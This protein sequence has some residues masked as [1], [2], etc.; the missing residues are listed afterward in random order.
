MTVILSQTDALAI[1]NYLADLLDG[2]KFEIY[3]GARPAN[4]Q[5]AVTTQTKLAEGTFPTPAFG[6]AAMSGVV[7]VATANAIAD[8][9]PIA[10][11]NA[12][13]VRVKDS[14]GTV[15]FDGSVS[16]PGGGGDMTITSTTIALGVTL[17][18][19]GFNIR[20]PTGQ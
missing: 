18:V 8:I 7:A 19:I 13:W 4:P 9:T 3:N 14:G 17:L 2:G 11:G 20:V 12:A 5:T 1:A 6:N 15:R 10:A 16:A